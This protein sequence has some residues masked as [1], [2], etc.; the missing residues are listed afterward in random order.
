MNTKT[1]MMT[2]IMIKDALCRKRTPFI[3][4]KADNDRLDLRF[5]FIAQEHV[6]DGLPEIEHAVASV[7]RNRAVCNRLNCTTL[8]NYCHKY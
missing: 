5:P 6:R 4:L 1:M 8:L 2:A 3:V 7:F